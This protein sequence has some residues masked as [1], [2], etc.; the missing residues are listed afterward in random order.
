V[1]CFYGDKDKNEDR[2]GFGKYAQQPKMLHGVARSCGDE[3]K[4]NGSF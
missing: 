1:R 3:E 4:T 2:E